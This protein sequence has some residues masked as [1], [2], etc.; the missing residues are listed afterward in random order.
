[1][2]GNNLNGLDWFGNIILIIIFM[3]I[4]LWIS[5]LILT[6]EDTTLENFDK[7]RRTTTAPL[8]N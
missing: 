5:A 2:N 7:E 4:A 6:C 3:I 1:M 8:D